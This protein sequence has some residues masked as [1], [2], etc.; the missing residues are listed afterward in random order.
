MSSKSM[1]G[2]RRLLLMFILEHHLDT[3]T[4]RLITFSTR[5]LWSNYCI[6]ILTKGDNSIFVDLDNA[7]LVH[8]RQ[9]T[10]NT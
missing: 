2:P 1:V 3:F 8:N 7:H 4:M 9:Y 10:D 6:V 5:L